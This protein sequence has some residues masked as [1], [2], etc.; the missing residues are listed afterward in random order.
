[1][2]KYCGEMDDGLS[3]DLIRTG[4]SEMVISQLSGP[5]GGLMD[6]LDKEAQ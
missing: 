1:M 3:H 5:N 4:S 2:Y 6:D